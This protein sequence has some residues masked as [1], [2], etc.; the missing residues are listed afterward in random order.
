MVTYFDAVN[1]ALERLDDLGYERGERNELVNHGPMAS[2]VLATLGHGDQIGTWV[3]VYR[4]KPHH[5]RPAPFLPL[6][7]SD[8]GSW[9]SAL[10]DFD[11][12]G[13]W[14]QLFFRE[15]T[16]AP[17]REVLVRWWPRLI[18]G[19]L[20]GITH[21]A[22]RTAHAVRSLSG[23]PQPSRAQLTELARGLAYWAA[24][25]RT[26]PGEADFRGKA[27]LAQAVAEIPREQLAE[28]LAPPKAR[29]ISRDRLNRISEIP[30]YTE[31]LH[32]VAPKDPELLL[33]EMTAEFAGLYLV[34]TEIYPIPLLH[35]VTLPAAVRIVLPHLPPEMRLPTVAAVWQ[36]HVALLLSF[37]GGR[38]GEDTAR[39]T[40][41]ETEVP[42]FGELIARAVEHKDEHVIKFTEACL[43]ENG[44]RPDPRYA[45][46]VQAAQLRIPTPETGLIP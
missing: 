16:E 25:Y 36:L 33:S 5:D 17:W 46:A 20:A 13:D 24:R 35:G 42:P 21:G 15:L 12:A 6:D 23:T 43:R 19:L 37:T 18:S 9:R 7:A 28:F 10:G 11:R 34:H 44:L 26:L 30:G 2:E 38:R 8:E 32:A 4:A 41:L 3:E 40:A 22:I 45:A 29:V 31:A 27:A 39:E 14:E 1:E